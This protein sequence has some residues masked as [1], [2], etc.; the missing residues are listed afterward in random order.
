MYNRHQV[1]GYQTNFIN[2][3]YKVEEQLQ[4]YDPHLFIM[5]NPN[6]GTWLIM[7][8]V[9]KLAIMKI[10]QTNFETLDSRLVSHIKKI[11]VG[12]GFNATWELQE[13]DDNRERESER[14]MDDMIEDYAKEMKPAL[15]QIYNTGRTDGVKTYY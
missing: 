7:D 11:H 4:S 5:F 3:I 2:D 13:A 10:P 15:R 6:D 12:N 9:T 1:K 8:D 14:V